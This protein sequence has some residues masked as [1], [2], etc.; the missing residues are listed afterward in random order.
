[1]HVFVLA[2]VIR[3]STCWT[4][5]RNHRAV[6]P[7]TGSRSISRHFRTRSHPSCR[8]LRAATISA[9][10]RLTLITSCSWSFD[11]AR[12]KLIL[13]ATRCAIRKSSGNQEMGF[14]PP[15]KTSTV[16]TREPLVLLE[17]LLHRLGRGHP[18]IRLNGFDHH[19]C[20]ARGADTSRCFDRH[21]LRERHGATTV[22]AGS[23]RGGTR[24]SVE[25]GGSEWLSLKRKKNRHVDC[26]TALSRSKRVRQRIIGA[27]SCERL[28]AAV[29]EI[30]LREISIHRHENYR[31]RGVTGLSLRL[32]RIEMSCRDKGESPADLETALLGLERCKRGCVDVVAPSNR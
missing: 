12:K 23:E 32:V 14:F 6:S 17:R 25:P 20:V 7:L 29:T 8:P 27:A 5:T 3:E 19:H 22:P 4:L 15:T 18:W 1:M 30:L 11:S 21:V 9:S 26:R 2:A 16:S 24:C 13:E 28:S 31:R 10:A